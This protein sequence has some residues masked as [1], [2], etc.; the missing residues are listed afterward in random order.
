MNPLYPH[1][2]EGLRRAC[3]PNYGFYFAW[4]PGMGKTLGAITYAR[5]MHASHIFIVT[6]KTGLGVW[7]AQLD[8]WWPEQT[9]DDTDIVILNYDALLTDRGE[10]VITSWTR[11]NH[12]ADLLV[13]DESHA[14]KNPQSL[15]YK[16]CKKLSDYAENRLLLSGTPAHS[17]L[18]Y[19]AQMQFV[20]PGVPPFN[21][22]FRDYRDWIAIK[23]GPHNTWIKGYKLDKVHEVQMAMAPFMHVS[24]ISELSLPE[25]IYTDVPYCLSPVETKAY[26]SMEVDLALT[27]EQCE[28]EAPVVLTKIMRLQQIASGFVSDEQHHNHNIGDSKLQACLDLLEERGALKVVVACRFRHEINRLADALAAKNRPYRMITGDTTAEYRKE[29]E[30]WFQS[31]DAPAVLLLQSAAGSTSLTL[32]AAA[33]LVIFSLDPSVITYQQLIGRVYRIGTAT[34][35]QVLTLV[36]DKTVEESML[37]GLRKG[38]DMVSLA[39]HIVH[40]I[41]H[42]VS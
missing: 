33:A 18:D 8:K 35:V 9:Y 2:V 4:Q 24:S 32:T 22:K 36:G 15:R 19:W 23:Y 30:E 12:G 7:R 11:A 13:L 3:H 41:R 39:R 5:L 16:A 42:A 10:R 6:T 28:I 34:H 40:Q 27:E 38:Y 37:D 29:T 1:Q 17:P 31:V 14:V 21:M 20:A 26:A 25:P